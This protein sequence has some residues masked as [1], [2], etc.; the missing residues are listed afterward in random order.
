VLELK[1]IREKTPVPGRILPEGL[2]QTARYAAQSKASEAHLIIC[3][4]RPGREWDD[5]I[6]ERSERAGDID[7]VVWGI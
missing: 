6:Y 4:E 7:I 5:K 3:D 1:T 2:E